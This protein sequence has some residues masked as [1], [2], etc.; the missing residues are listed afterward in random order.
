MLKGVILQPT[1]TF[2]VFPLYIVIGL[3][4][5]AGQKAGNGEVEQENNFTNLDTCSF[6]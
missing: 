3:S 4:S 5:M 1:A 6:A 2:L